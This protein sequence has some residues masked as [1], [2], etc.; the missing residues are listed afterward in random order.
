MALPILRI[1]TAVIVLARHIALRAL[2]I[3][4]ISNEGS[5]APTGARVQRHPFGGPIVA[6]KRFRALR[7]AQTAHAVRAPGTPASRRSTAAIF[8]PQARLGETVERCKWA[9]LVSLA[10]LRSQVPLV[11]AE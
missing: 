4:L 5:G 3:S 1:Q 9:V 8:W 10:L 6:R 2:P 7:P 11:V